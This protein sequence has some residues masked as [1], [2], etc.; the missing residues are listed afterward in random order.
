MTV[1][2]A[3]STRIRRPNAYRG[4]VADIP[5]KVPE[6]GAVAPYR[7][8][9]AHCGEPYVG[10]ANAAYCTANCAKYA[11]LDRLRADQAP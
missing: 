8:Q 9:C 6:G 10:P 7:G 5:R 3:P 1:P 4:R 11:S 2:T